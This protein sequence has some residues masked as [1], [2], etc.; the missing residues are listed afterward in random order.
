[1]PAPVCLVKHL[2]TMEY[3]RAWDLQVELA[4]AIRRGQQPNTL[5][6]LE[7]PHVYTRGRLSQPQHLRLSHEQLSAIGISLYDTDRGGQITY[8]GPGQLVAYPVVDLREWGGPIKYVRN[9]EQIIIKMLSDFGIHAGR[10]EGLTGVWCA[11]AKIAAIGVKISRGVAYHGL[12]V[13]VNTDLSYYGYIVPCGIE[14]KP[15]TSMGDLL[16]GLVDMD[17]VRYSLVY[18]FGTSMGFRMV[19][20]EQ[21]DEVLTAPARPD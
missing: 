8:H 18:H 9:L 1:M 19:G 5:L 13:N 16:G 15:V 21:A 17:M 10:E 7:H 20:V 2:G 6:L 3:L 4:Q 12:A 14:D 11:G